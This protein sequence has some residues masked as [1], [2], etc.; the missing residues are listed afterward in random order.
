MALIVTTNSQHTSQTASKSRTVIASNSLGG[1]ASSVS[2]DKLAN[3][4][5][6]DICGKKCTKCVVEK[7]LADF[8]TWKYGR[9]GYASWCRVCT[10][11]SIREWYYR[12]KEKR[13]KQQAEWH[14]RNKEWR[15][16]EALANY[17]ASDR[18]AW[19]KRA[20][21]WAEKNPERYREMMRNA[22]NRRRARKLGAA[23]RW[24]EADVRQRFS[25]QKGRCAVCRTSLGKSF[26]RDHIVALA[27]GGSND[28]SNL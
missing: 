25:Q 4:S 20:K 9:T 10:N 26:H 16:A 1:S 11:A 7:P 6:I 2:S 8:P 24:T 17:Y 3:M 15:N 28:K 19:H 13:N 22:D 14:A 12:N 21:E 27:A 5:R 18:K 23:G